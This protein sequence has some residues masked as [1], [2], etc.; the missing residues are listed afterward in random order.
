VSII[1]VVR[2][3]A[4]PLAETIKSVRAQTYSGI[5]FIVVDG[6]STDGTL[7]VVRSAG[8]DRWISEPDT[9]LYDAMNKGKRLAR[10]D[11]AMFVNSGDTFVDDDV[12]TRFVSAVSDRGKLYFGRVRLTDCT[13]KLSWEVPIMSKKRLMPPKSYLPHHQSILYPRQFFSIYDYDPAM[14]YRAD[15]QYTSKACRMLEREFINLT[16]IHSRLGGLTSRA[17]TSLAELREEITKETALARH[18]AADTGNLLRLIDVTI[19]TFVKYLASK[20]GGLPLVHRLMYTKQV[21]RR[22]VT[23]IG[24]E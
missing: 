19:G 23:S 18:I 17:I 16:L 12:M 15:V 7:E 22:W 3:A 1:T 10:G 2:N 8:I 11:F 14:G 20:A 9:G 24:G 13:G 21:M 6:A 5:E 4:G